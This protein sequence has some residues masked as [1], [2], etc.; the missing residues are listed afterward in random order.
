MSACTYRFYTIA[1]IFPIS[2]RR[3]CNLPDLFALSQHWHP[4]SKVLKWACAYV[5]TYVVVDNNCTYTTS[6][7]ILDEGGWL[8]VGWGLTWLFRLLAVPRRAVRLCV[9]V[10]IF[11]V[12]TPVYSSPFAVRTQR[13]CTQHVLLPLQSLRSGQTSVSCRPRVCHRRLTDNQHFAHLSCLRSVTWHINARFPPLCTFRLYFSLSRCDGCL[14]GRLCLGRLSAPS[15]HIN[16]HLQSCRFFGDLPICDCFGFA[17][18]FILVSLSVI[19]RF[20]HMHTNTFPLIQ[21]ICMCVCV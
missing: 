21:Y 11:N 9:C 5:C 2:R 1:S 19:F 12:Y 6:T 20:V 8:S 16:A 7:W 15:Q 13:V 3:A 17:C 10:C 14:L 18:S 4:H